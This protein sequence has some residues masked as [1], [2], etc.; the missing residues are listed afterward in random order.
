MIKIDPQDA[1]GPYVLVTPAKDEEQYISAT[2]DSVISQ[3]PPPSE[4]VIVDDSSSDRTAEIG[5]EAARAY[6]WIR[7]IRRPS[8]GKRDFTAVVKA[9]ET[10][11]DSINYRNHEFVGFLDADVVLPPGY[12]RALLEG[13]V[14]NHRLGLSGGL[15]VDPD[16]KIPRIPNNLQDVPGAVQFFRREC[17]EAIGALI[18]IPAGGWD[19]LTCA[20]S[21]MMGWETR[22]MVNLI[23]RHLKPRNAGISGR[24]KRFFD[25]GQRDRAL[26]YHPL[27]ELLKCLSRIKDR[28]LLIGS[29]F[30]WMGYLYASFKGLRG[31]VPPALISHIRQEQR[32][33]IKALFR[34][35]LKRLY[36]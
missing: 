28:P 25:F 8:S 19:M 7:V 11:L 17:L 30:W 9:I 20:C 18:P 6:P 14:Q 33:R 12:F 16:E 1:F 36:T 27:F 5:E 32:E 15:V 35:P 21:R 13:F 4:W 29:L 2:I 24:T 26:Y 34:S 31:P 3:K 22:L 10:G 23:V